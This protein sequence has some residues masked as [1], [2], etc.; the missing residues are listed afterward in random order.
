MTLVSILVTLVASL[1]SGL[2]GAGISLWFFYYKL[3]RRKLKLDLTRRL[4]GYRFSIKGDGFSCAMNEVI[5]VFSDS[6]DVLQK[7]G[8]LYQVLQTEGKP[9][10]ESAL[11]DFLKSVC[12]NSR[13]TQATLNDSYII[14]TFNARN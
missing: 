7:M 10:V 8:D 3:E 14:K 2:A 11:I 12:E 9:N 13:L 4:L 6:P 5:A 1:M